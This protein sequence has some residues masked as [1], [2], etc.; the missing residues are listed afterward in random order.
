MYCPVRGGVSIWSDSRSGQATS[1][2]LSSLTAG[3]SNGLR[4][5]AYLAP[6]GSC[7]G[8]LRGQEL[9]RGRLWGAT[10]SGKFPAHLAGGPGGRPAR[11][12]RDSA[13]RSDRSGCSRSTGLAR[14]LART[15]KSWERCGPSR[16]EV[17]F[18][19][20]SSALWSAS[21]FPQ[22]KS[23]LKRSARQALRTMR[24]GIRRSIF[25]VVFPEP[26]PDHW[27]A[28]SASEV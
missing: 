19:R 18:L 6:S 21:L 4:P 27:S 10:G 8:H 25:L 28:R 23:G 14:R 22:V 24:T 2:G 9:P 20:R 12:S 3:S 16:G 17:S 13:R 7:T 5:P 15:A 1:A 11:A 26:H